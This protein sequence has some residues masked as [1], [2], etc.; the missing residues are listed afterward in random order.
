MLRTMDLEVKILRNEKI[1]K[2]VL[3]KKGY[4]AKF[5]RKKIIRQKA[6]NEKVPS[7]KK[8][9]LHLSLQLQLSI[10]KST[11]LPHKANSIYTQLSG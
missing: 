7:R 4:R 10:T 9:L 2:E 8:I 3:M 1:R 5:L 6:L 11:L